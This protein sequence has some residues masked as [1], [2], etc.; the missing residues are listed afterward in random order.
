[1]VRTTI[2]AAL[3]VAA[4]ATAVLALAP[5]APTV[6]HYSQTIKPTHIKSA[7]LKNCLENQNEC[8]L[9]VY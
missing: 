7:V 1:M 6:G 5:S 9:V 3:L 4:G 8:A 2:L